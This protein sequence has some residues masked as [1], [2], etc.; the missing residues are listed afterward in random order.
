M[1][2]AVS[3]DMDSPCDVAGWVGIH[4][5]PVVPFMQI[6]PRSSCNIEP[7]KLDGGL[8]GAARTAEEP[9]SFDDRLKE[10]RTGFSVAISAQRPQIRYGVVPA[11]P[12]DVMDL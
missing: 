9:R 1:E 10:Q 5:T 8:G 6:K 3:G 4:A 12:V 2:P 11:V 7:S